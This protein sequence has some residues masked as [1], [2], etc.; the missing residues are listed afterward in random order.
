MSEVSKLYGFV[1]SR[2]LEGTY[3][4]DPGTG[5]WITTA[6]RVMRGWG[7]V[8]EH[9]WPAQKWPPDEPPGLDLLAKKRRISAYQRVRDLG[10][11]KRC[12][13]GGVQIQASFEI[14]VKEW[15]Q[16]PGGIIPMPRSSLGDGH[17]I[18]I[19][20]YDDQTRRLR[21]WNSWGADWGDGGYGYLPYDYYT[22]LVTEASV[23]FF[24]VDEYPARHDSPFICLTWGRG[25]LHD[26]LH[27]IELYEPTN[28]ER[29]GWCFSVEV[30][31][32]LDVEE[33]FVKPAYRRQGHGKKLRSEL[34]A[35]A[36]R[37]QL[38]PRVWIAHPD[39]ASLDIAVRLLAPMNLTVL[40]SPERWAGYVAVPGSP[41]P[42]G[43]TSLPPP[44]AYRRPANFRN[45]A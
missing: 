27:G 43:I 44:P 42:P 16:A 6:N 18:V 14:S 20:A 17:S 9:D 22:A 25:Y 1:R 30:D 23:P 38:P 12:L 35:L 13:D 37:L 7:I 4:G 19:E 28:A 39:V 36:R 45:A 5:V 26:C 32:F 21:F 11:V 24:T 29:V 2:Q 31:G 33:L 15:G 3:P 8:A 10:H 34:N 40:P 41:G